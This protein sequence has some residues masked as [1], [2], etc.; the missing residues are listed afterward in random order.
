MKEAPVGRV[1][2]DHSERRNAIVDEVFAKPALEQH[3]HAIAASTAE[4]APLT[5]RSTKRVIGA[6]AREDAERDRDAMRRS[7]LSCFEREDAREGVCAFLARR[8]PFFRGR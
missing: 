2:F 1:V 4:S 7:I 5:L 6:L 3:V 8:K